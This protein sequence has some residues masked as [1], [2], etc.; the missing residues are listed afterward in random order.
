MAGR[1]KNQKNI[2]IDGG[3]TTVGKG[4][5]DSAGEGESAVER[6]PGR[7]SGSLSLLG[8]CDKESI[9][10]GMRSIEAETRVHRG[11]KGGMKRK[12][13]GRKGRRGRENRK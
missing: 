6:K 8:H 11:M 13:R 7:G 1:T 9:E 3:E 12:R 10:V 5:A 2:H 4:A